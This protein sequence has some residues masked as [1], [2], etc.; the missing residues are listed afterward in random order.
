MSRLE[1]ILLVIIGL[2]MA[3][4]IVFGNKLLSELIS[5]Y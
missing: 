2:M 4:G 3:I 1:K 5:Y